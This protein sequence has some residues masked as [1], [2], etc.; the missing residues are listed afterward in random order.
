MSR[1]RPVV[2]GSCGRRGWSLGWRSPS[3]SCSS[4]LTSCRRRFRLPW[5]CFSYRD[6]LSRERTDRRCDCGRLV[7]GGEAEGVLDLDQAGVLQSRRVALGV[8][9]REDLVLVGPDQQRG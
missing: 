8:G 6:R 3:T 1:K 2:G 4:G 5:L 7:L 9:K